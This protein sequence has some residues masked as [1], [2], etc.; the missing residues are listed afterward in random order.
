MVEN[1]TETFHPFSKEGNGEQENRYESGILREKNINES[2]ILQKRKQKREIIN[3]NSEGKW[4]AI[5]DRN[6]NGKEILENQIQKVSE[7]IFSRHV[8]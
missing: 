1:G 4:G 5:F 2:G 7:Y 8:L 3:E 6:E